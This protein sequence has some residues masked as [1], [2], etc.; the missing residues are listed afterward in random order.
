MT[1]KEDYDFTC[2][3]L[4]QHGS[5]YRA[6]RMF[7]AA[8]HETNA[9]GA[10]DARDANGNKERDNIAI[11]QQKWPG[12]FYINGRRGDA[13]QVVMTWRRRRLSQ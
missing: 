8:V 2:E 1:L 6:N 7:V 3:H 5:V 10:V 4:A 12:V 9:G 13:T 11:L